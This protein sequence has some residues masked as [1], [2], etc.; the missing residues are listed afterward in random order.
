[1]KR[2]KVRKNFFPAEN[3]SSIYIYRAYYDDRTIEGT[4]RIFALSKCFLPNETFFMRS[5]GIILPLF[6]QPLEGSCPWSY[7]KSC[8]WNAHHLQSPK[9]SGLIPEKVRMHLE[10]PDNCFC[11]YRLCSRVVEPS[12]FP[13]RRDLRWFL[14]LSRLILFFELWSSHSPN[15]IIY[16][17]SYSRNVAK[18]LEYYEKQGIVQ[19]VNWP[20][21]NRSDD[22]VDPNAG[23]YRLSHSLA[24]ND[25]VMRMEAEIGGLVDIDE[26]IHIPGNATLLEFAKQKFESN[27]NL[28][29][30]MFTHRGLQPMEGTFD[31]LSHTESINATGPNKSIFKPASVK[32]LS[33]HWVH[34]HRPANLQRA[35]IAVQ[36]GIL[37][38][39]RVSFEDK[40]LKNAFA[41]Q[42][43]DLDMVE[44]QQRA[45]QRSREIFGEN[46]PPHNEQV[47][48][49]ME[50]CN[51]NW[52]SMG[53]KV[54]LL[55]CRKELEKTDDWVFLPPS[56]DSHY[57]MM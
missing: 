47:S 4:I 26:Y 17:N 18:V 21:L 5:N 2:F 39:N 55:Q 57:E 50:K 41:S 46:L 53:C 31:G 25:C 10:L 56:I 3:Q 51:Q 33:T 54:P 30:L 1:S 16:A 45:K 37:L 22:G 15:F 13:L 38:H 19:I 8:D 34:T 36:E 7:A 9:I 27:T 44:I 23:I 20:V 49:V 35:K 42:F 11:R 14:T 48:H 12:T 29:S 32:F 28:G 6:I 43:D 24:H 52:R 40:D